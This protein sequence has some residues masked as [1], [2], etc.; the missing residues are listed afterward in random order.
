MDLQ[1]EVTHHPSAASASST[2]HLVQS[3]DQDVHPFEQKVSPLENSEYHQS[4]SH[5]TFP[6][7]TNEKLG[8]TAIQHSIPNP[9]N[10]W[11]QT[12]SEQ[13]GPGLFLDICAGAS[14]GKRL[15]L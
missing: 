12:V 5:D 3:T 6:D 10:S 1:E 2:Q 13:A 4:Q 7:T 14:R 11:I 15:C 9:S 8:N